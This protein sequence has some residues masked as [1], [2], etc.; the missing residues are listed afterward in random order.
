MCHVLWKCQDF[1]YYVF[2]VCIV[3]IDV[4]KVHWHTNHCEKST[5][6]ETGHSAGAMFRQHDTSMI[7]TV[8]IFEAHTES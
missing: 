8:I 6:E 2:Y 5:M 1:W 7:S 4:A 3:C